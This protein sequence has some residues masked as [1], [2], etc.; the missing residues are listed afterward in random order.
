MTSIKKSLVLACAASILSMGVAFA[1]TDPN[2]APAAGGMAAP[3]AG[4]T[5]GGDSM[6]K[7]PMMKKPMM[8]KHMSKKHMKKPMAKPM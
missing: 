8:K 3:A 2:A 1:Q 6:M 7:K 4:D 5:A